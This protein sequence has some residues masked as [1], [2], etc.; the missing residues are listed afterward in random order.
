[1]NVF[2]FDVETVPDT[3]IGI[4]EF[5]LSKGQLDAKDIAKAMFS[6]RRAEGRGEFLPHYK[7]K[8]VAISVLFRSQ[9][10]DL[11]LWS[12]GSED[13]SEG[14]LISRFFAGIDKY[15]PILVSYNAAGFD[16]PLLH[17]RALKHGVSATTYFDVGDKNPDFKWNNYLNRYHNRHIDLMDVLSN[18]S[19]RAV[20]NLDAVAGLLKLPGKF[21]IDGSAV[22]D[23]YFDGKIKEIREYCETDVLNTY[24]VYLHFELLRGNLD[25]SAHTQEVD[26]VKSYLRDEDKS[27]LNEYLEH[28]E[29]INI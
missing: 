17:Y 13:S 29:A 8:I 27:H 26:L 22:C 10:G 2:V 16:L 9:A 19:A 23:Y 6:A 1:M 18:Y 5:G 4:A 20:T 11:K 15:R 3:D 28:W 25:K 14:E 21:G 7:H 24:L 12:L